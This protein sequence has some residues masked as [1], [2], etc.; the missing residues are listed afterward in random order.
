MRIQKDT[1]YKPRDISKYKLIVSSRGLCS[2]NFVLDEIAA[3][4]LTAEDFRK[5]GGKTPYYRVKGS[6][7]IRYRKANKLFL[8]EDN[9]TEAQE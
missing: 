2:Y 9:E 1:Y 4:R 7:L 5:P 3:G 8:G 6:E